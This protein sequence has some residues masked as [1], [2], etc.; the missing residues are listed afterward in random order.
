LPETG[1][2]LTT[3]GSL[4]YIKAVETDSRKLNGLSLDGGDAVLGRNY[5]RDRAPHV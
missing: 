2:T 1:E 5:G 3:P 4:M